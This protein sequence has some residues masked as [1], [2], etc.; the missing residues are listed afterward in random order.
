MNSACGSARSSPGCAGGRRD[1]TSNP[2]ACWGLSG[3]LRT[4]RRPDIT[5]PDLKPSDE[6]LDPLFEKFYERVKLPDLMRKTDYHTLAPFVPLELIDAEIRD[7][8]D[9]IVTV[10]QRA[11]P[12][13]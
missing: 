5:S 3:A 2:S 11:A 6:F 7:K 8:L 13:R 1:S 10:A 12:R 9:A 4:L